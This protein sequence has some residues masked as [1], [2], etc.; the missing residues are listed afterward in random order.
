MVEPIIEIDPAPLTV[1]AAAWKVSLGW[2][3]CRDVPACCGKRLPGI[4]EPLGYSTF[5]ASTAAPSQP[6]TGPL[7]PSEEPAPIPLPLPGLMLVLAIAA[8]GLL[9][10][11]MTT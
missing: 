3:E 11:R 10:T 8:I 7:P 1:E 4:K 5:S 6:L 9:K 2:V